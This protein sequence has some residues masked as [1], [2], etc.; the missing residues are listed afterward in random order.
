MF[1]RYGDFERGELSKLKYK[2]RAI[3][4]SLTRLE[5]YISILEN[6]EFDLDELKIRIEKL[7]ETYKSFTDVQIEIAIM[8]DTIVEADLFIES[9]EVENKYIQI[10]VATEK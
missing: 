1:Y 10:R 3:K 4:A 8:D 7:E 2:K 9:E 6:N 5:T